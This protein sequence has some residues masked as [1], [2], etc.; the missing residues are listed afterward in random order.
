MLRLGMWQCPAC[1]KRL[2]VT[3]GGEAAPADV[4]DIA[5]RFVGMGLPG[6]AA[7][8]GRLL[9]ALPGGKPPRKQVAGSWKQ[10]KGVSAGALACAAALAEDAAA[11]R[12]R[13]TVTATPATHLLALTQVR[14]RIYYSTL[15]LFD[16]AM[17]AGPAALSFRRQKATRCVPLTRQPNSIES[18]APQLMKC[19]HR[20]RWRSCWRRLRWRRRRRRRRCWRGR[21]F[22]PDAARR[23]SLHPACASA[24]PQQ[25]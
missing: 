12:G 15:M 25:V 19:A 8:A 4:A 21:R 10:P 13:F 24:L 6:Q 20:C 2:L 17:S 9:A 7:A 16:L 14:R 3:A 23:R 18:M 1:T 11:G 5:R 22:K